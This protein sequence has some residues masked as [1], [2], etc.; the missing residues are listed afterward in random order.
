MGIGSLVVAAK[1]AMARAWMGQKSIGPNFQPMFWASSNLGMGQ[2]YPA[3]VQLQ[4]G[5]YHSWVYA[6]C[7]SIIQPFV[8]L[9]VV[10]YS[11]SNEE[12]LIEEN[13]VLDLIKKP[14]PFMSG[15]NFFEAILWDLLLTTIRTPG[16]Q[17]F[18]IGEKPT[19]FRKGEIPKELWVFGD[20][21][22]SPRLDSQGILIGWTLG[23][24]ATTMPLELDQVIRINLFNKYDW[25]QGM[26]PLAAALIEVDQD[27]KAK[28]FNTKFL[29]NNAMPGGMVSIEGSPPS[30]EI[31]EELKTQFKQQY[32]GYQNA[33]K[34][35]FMPW[36]LKFEQFARAH[37]DF[38]YMEQLGWNRDSILAVY[39]VNKWSVGISEDLNFATAKE[40]TRQ[41]IERAV[42][43]LARVVFT[44]LNENWIRYIGKRD[45]RMKLDLSEAQ[46]L[47]EDRSVKIKDAGAL[48]DQGVPPSAAYDY[49]GLDIDTKPFPWLDEDRSMTGQFARGLEQEKEEEREA[50]KKPVEAEKPN[51][52]AR[53]VRV[54]K[55]ERDNLSKHFIDKVFSPGE[56]E[57]IPVV[58]RFFISQRN[59]M[60]AY[61]KEFLK[62]L[63]SANGIDA[64]RL[65]L[66]LGE[67]N[68]AIIK[69]FQPL[70]IS[71]VKRT[72]RQLRGEMKALN[73]DSTEDEIK[74]FLIS[75]LRALSE[76]NNTTFAGLEKELSHILTDGI[77]QHQTM[78]ELGK[79]IHDGIFEVY[80]GRLKHTGMIARTETA[81]VT[82]GVRFEVFKTNNINRQEWLT[83]KDSRVRETHLQE[84]GNIVSL[85]DA[86]PV[87]GL[88]H[89][90]DPSGPPEEVINCRCVAL[91]VEED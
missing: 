81:T 33:G 69:S 28:E 46:A 58:T 38:S 70:F 19:N 90:N 86:F 22:M 75:R 48:I 89:P 13:P 16:G 56:K 31:Y 63:D 50:D 74:Q 87:T 3:N 32:T 40:A 68:T 10:M 84:D 1:D 73:L 11:K 67:Q 43:P 8:D 12:K 24:G 64:K 27:A 76:I 21:G 6:A 14:N 7:N 30:R 82:N 17:A 88:V 51:K 5:R 83:A 35:L 91:P 80:Q 20:E 4:P 45:L 85:G 79:A 34:N 29:E 71:Q 55:D 54:T 26:S 62:G 15:T 44:A 2:S 61:T 60:Q 18:I 49:V 66:D 57:L 23:I 52:S 59:D 9:P 37:I 39:R 77:D 41:L 65:L 47:K 25:K 36:M 78:V 72:F 53:L 42:L